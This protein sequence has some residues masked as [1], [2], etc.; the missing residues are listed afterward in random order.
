[1]NCNPQASETLNGPVTRSQ[2]VPVCDSHDD[3]SRETKI[4]K[5][6]SLFKRDKRKIFVGGL[7]IDRTL[8]RLYIP[9]YRSCDI[10]LTLDCFFSTLYF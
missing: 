7:P 4:K 10:I 8:S 6:Y 2:S 1:M 9:R 5:A 3:L